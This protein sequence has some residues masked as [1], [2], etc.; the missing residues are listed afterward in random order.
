MKRLYE[1]PYPRERL[2]KGKAEKCE[3]SANAGKINRPR[4]FISVKRIKEKELSKR[5]NRTLSRLSARNVER[6][7]RERRELQGR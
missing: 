1:E 2:R 6:G 4:Q 3:E 7:Q 5:K